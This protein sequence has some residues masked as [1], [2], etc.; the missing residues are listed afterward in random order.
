VVATGCGR[1][2]AGAAKPEAPAKVANP[3]KETKLN[4]IEL[5]EEAEKRLGLQTAKVEERAFVR[6]RPYAGEVTLPASALLMVSAPV[7]GTLKVTKGQEDIPQVG[8]TV[9][10]GQVLFTLVPHVLTQAETSSLAVAQLTLKTAQVNAHSQVLQA[11]VQL[12]AAQ[13]VFDRFH[14]LVSEAAEA[15][16]KEEDA[17]AKL[18]LAQSAYDAALDLKKLVDGMKLEKSE[19]MI[20]PLAIPS[21]RQG[22]LRAT[23]A[24][25]GETVAPGA[26]LFEIMNPHT[27]WIKV[28]VYVGELADIAE[29]KPVQVNSL[30]DPPGTRGVTA[31]AVPAP[32]TAQPQA[33]AVDLYYE[34][35]NADGKY[36]PGQRVGVLVPLKDKEKSLAV[37]W[38]SVVHDINGGT[39]VY[40]QTAP[41]TYARQRVQVKYVTGDSAVLEQGPQSGAD[42]VTAGAAEVFGAEFGFGK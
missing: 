40:I 20:K 14:K 21:P 12:E 24:V 7:G 18:D 36:R 17:K 6:Q 4:T 28:P 5:T 38:T 39:W 32:P 2:P 3:P 26:A 19:G 27:V 1:K 23:F 13:V 16:D 30:S 41:R 31:K 42:V 10:Q 15:K 11:K 34:L 37:P 25:P 35:A 29:K 9:R 8:S 22:I 33:S